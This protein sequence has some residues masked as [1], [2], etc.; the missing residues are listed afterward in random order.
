[1]FR[2]KNADYELRR[3][4]LFESSF[5]LPQPDCRHGNLPVMGFYGDHAQDRRRRLG[6]KDRGTQ[7]DGERARKLA[8]EVMGV[9]WMNWKVGCQAI[10]PAYSEFIGRQAIQAMEAIAC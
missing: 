3:H 9:D 10:P 2:L 8:L 7:L 6:S 5:P 4:R 1:M